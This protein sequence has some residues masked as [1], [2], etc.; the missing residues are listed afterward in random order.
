MSFVWD[1]GQYRD[2]KEMKTFKEIKE[3]PYLSNLQTQ[4]SIQGLY[5]LYT[6]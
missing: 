2:R 6:R 5:A 4:P 3:V 1:Y